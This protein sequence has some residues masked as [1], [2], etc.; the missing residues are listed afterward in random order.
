MID[1]LGKLDSCSSKCSVIQS[2]TQN[3]HTNEICHKR[4]GGSWNVVPRK[5]EKTVTNQDV[6][7]WC[8]NITELLKK[9]FTG[10]FLRCEAYYHCQ[11][12][13]SLLS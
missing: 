4:D 7:T 5:T 8:N 10:L 1:D 3:K 12:S 2:G 9:C 6:A 11:V 13:E